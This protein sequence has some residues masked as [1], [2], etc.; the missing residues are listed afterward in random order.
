MDNIARRKILVIDDELELLNLLQ[1]V[2]EAKGYQAFCATSGAA[3]IRLHDREHPDLIVLDLRMPEM[4]GIEVLRRIRQRD[5][6]VRVVIL[7]AFGGPNTIRDAAA[8][9]VS[10]YLS[11]PFDNEELIRVIGA[12]LSRP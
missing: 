9:D 10:E 4:D 5:P 8:L 3:G 11:K 7:T 12:A 6:V 1:A 2:L